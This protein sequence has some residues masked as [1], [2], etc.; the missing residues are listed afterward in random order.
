[1][2]K[3]IVSVGTLMLVDSGRLR[4]EDPLSRYVPEFANATVYGGE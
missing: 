2:T 1:M 3:P 4:L